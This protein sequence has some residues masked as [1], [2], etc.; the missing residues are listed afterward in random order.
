MSNRVPNVVA[1]IPARGGSK[2]VPRKN[3]R[4]VAGMPLIAWT[5]KSAQ[6]SA[7]FSRVV[8]STDDTEIAAVA[9]A[10]GAEVPFLRPG[11][12]ATDSAG[13]LEVVEH[14]LSEIGGD[15]DAVMLLQ[16]TSPLRSYG[17]ITEAVAVLRSRDADAVVSVTAAAHPPEWFC[18]IAGD[19]TLLPNDS[20]KESSQRQSAG[21]LYQLNGA[22][23][24]IR[25]QALRAERTFIPPKTLAYVMPQDRS[26]DID[27]EFDLQVAA[28]VL[29][30]SPPTQ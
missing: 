8:V 26:L 6:Q 2:A 20:L 19:G 4:D 13:S 3:V 25:A 10:W 27:T 7:A 12:L 18:H 15:F 30:A 1:I 22:I 24:L 14:A 17:D 9:N 5:I 28:L 23:Y 29:R 16:P 11:R 21:A